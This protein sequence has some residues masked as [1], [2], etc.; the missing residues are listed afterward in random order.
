VER[1]LLVTLAMSCS[2]SNFL[3]G[4]KWSNCAIYGS[5]D[6]ASTMRDAAAQVM[7][8]A[9]RA[10]YEEKKLKLR[11][12]MADGSLH[13]EESVASQDLAAKIQDGNWSAVINEQ[14]KETH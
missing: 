6:W 3:S 2:P 13:K 4:R 14:T 7:S 9:D 8:E 12:A 10:V 5:A 1:N 11:K